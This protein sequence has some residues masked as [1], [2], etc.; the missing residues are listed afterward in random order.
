[1][2]RNMN[3]DPWA[4]S[5]YQLWIVTSEEPKNTPLVEY[6]KG[7]KKRFTIR[8]VHGGYFTDY[9]GKASQ[10]TKVNFITFVDIDLL[11]M[12]ML[13]SFS[14]R[15]GCTTVGYWYH[16]L[17]E[18]HSSL[19][20]TPILDDYALRNFKSIVRAHEFHEIEYLYVEHKPFYMLTNFPRF[21]MNS[22]TKRD[23][24][25]IHLFV[26]EHLVSTVD[27]GITYIKHMLNITIPRGKMEDAMD[28]A[29]ENVIAWKDLV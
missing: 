2:A 18:Q 21:M 7:N 8:V 16:M 3:V 20:M 1:M 19:S 13:G 6:G 10:K 23:E 29:K 5:R 9:P 27:D 11:D 4:K 26:T 12:D 17:T 15:L 24:K 22:P 28:M 14:K 25:H